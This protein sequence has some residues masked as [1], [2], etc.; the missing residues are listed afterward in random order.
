MSKNNIIRRKRR[1]EKSE[2][3]APKKMVGF[4]FYIV[5]LLVGFDDLLLDTGFNLTGFLAV[6]APIVSNFITLI[7][8]FY[9]Y[10]QK[11]SPTSNKLSL[12][13]LSIIIEFIPFIN[14]FPTY[15]VSLLITK[16]L[17]NNPTARKIVTAK[18]NNVIRSKNS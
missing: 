16:K 5:L 13:I 4:W 6:L 1:G 2:Q 7:T 9:L 11:I 10:T 8:G 12:W 14:L 15:L 17:E 3:L 18:M